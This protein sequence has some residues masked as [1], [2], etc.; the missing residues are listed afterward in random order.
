MTKLNLRRI[1]LGGLVGGVVWVAWSFFL[2]V[3]LLAPRYA[4]AQQDGFFLAQPRYPF[5]MPA[6]LVT[7]LLLSLIL[8]WLYAAVRA[9]WG[10]GPV[11]A[12]KLGALVGFAAG[13]PLSFSSAAWLPA[14]RIFPLGW[15][16]E[17]WIGAIIAT[18]IAGWLYRES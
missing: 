10:P 9:V 14:P 12:L 8:A 13:F 7:L 16:L 15:L 1:L 18:F 11:T 17:L 3:A 4:K 6:W 5:F 2:N